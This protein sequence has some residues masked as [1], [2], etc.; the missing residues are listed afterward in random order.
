MGIPLIFSVVFSSICIVSLYLGIYTLY[1]NP[2]SVTNRLFF[3]L[4]TTLF[5]WSFGFA[6]AISAADLPTCLF[7]RR[8]AAIGWGIFFSVLLHFIISLTGRSRLLNRWW[9]YA[10]LYL[11]AGVCLSVF[12]YLPGYFPRLNPNQYNLVQTPMGWVNVSIKNPWDW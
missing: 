9:K 3:A 2:G 1:T 12:T 6:M 4:T 7:W 11:P 8:F 5:I 10:L